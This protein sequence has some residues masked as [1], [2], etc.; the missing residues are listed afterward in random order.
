MDERLGES[1]AKQE[2]ECPM[3]MGQT[4]VKWLWR[5]TEMRKDKRMLGRRAQST[6][7]EVAR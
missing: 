1:G 4:G 7:L 6:R 2:R 3:S 5:V